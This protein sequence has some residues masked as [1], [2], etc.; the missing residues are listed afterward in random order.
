MTIGDQVFVIRN[1][2]GI[3][4]QHH[5]IDCGNGLVIHYAGDFGQEKPHQ[6]IQ[7]YYDDF[8]KGGLIQKVEYQSEDRFLFSGQIVVKRAESRLGE[9]QYH[10]FKNN[11][12]HFATWCKTGQSICRQAN[13]YRVTSNLLLSGLFPENNWIKTSFISSYKMTQS[14]KHQNSVYSSFYKK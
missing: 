9:K 1:Y 12:E 14:W 4:F 2:R 10:L 13:L 3:P 8:A 7:E 11:C 6:V 5:G